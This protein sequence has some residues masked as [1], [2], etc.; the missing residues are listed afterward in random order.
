MTGLIERIGRA[1]VI[2]PHPDDEVLGCGGVLARLADAG[3]ATHVAIVTEGRA[4]QYTAAHAATL[5]KETRAA[6]A[7]LG[8]TD[9]H[10]IGLPAA[11]LDQVAHAAVN[12]L[13]AELVTSVAPDTL[14]V[15]FGGDVHLDH[16]LVFASAMVAARPN[17]ET[18]PVRILAY[19][20]MSETNWNAPGISPAFVPNVFIDISTTL[21]R[22]LAAM[23]AYKSQ[24]RP[25]PSERSIEA[26]AAL[27]R[28]RGSTVYR[29]AAEAFMLIREVG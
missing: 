14:F 22:K 16:Q 25:L 23:A 6:Q 27:A 19:E 17:R 9:V 5:G 26:L 21:D 1:L 11:A 24:V 29:S 12:S 2:A 3:K 4:P 15:P 13:I 10:Y 18:Y 7:L 8:I 28:V 20:T